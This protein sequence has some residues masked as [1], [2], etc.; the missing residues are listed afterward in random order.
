MDSTFITELNSLME[1][2]TFSLGGKVLTQELLEETASNNREDIQNLYLKYGF[3]PPE[4]NGTYLRKFIEILVEVGTVKLYRPMNLSNDSNNVE[5]EPDSMEAE[6]GAE[7]PN[8]YELTDHDIE[9]IH[10]LGNT[11]DATQWSD[12]FVYLAERLPTMAYDTALMDEWFAK[13]ILTGYNA[14]RKTIMHELEEARQRRDVEKS[15]NDY[16]YVEYYDRGPLTNDI[17]F[18]E[19]KFKFDSENDAKRFIELNINND[20]LKSKYYR[21]FKLEPVTRFEK[22]EIK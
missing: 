5:K 13:A 21:I 16:V 22:R 8:E 3:T 6:H 2:V 20:Y 4:I 10:D 1:E 7:S 18:I 11:I 15:E 9:R 12:V 19:A 14:G 17:E